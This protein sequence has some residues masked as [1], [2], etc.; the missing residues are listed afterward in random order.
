MSAA[1]YQYSGFCAIDPKAY[2]AEFPVASAPPTPTGP[3]ETGAAVISLAGPLCYTSRDFVTYDMILNAVRCAVSIEGAHTVALIVDSPGGDVPGAFDTAR[4]L[5]RI[6]KGAGKRFLAHTSS[7]A[8]SA[9]YALISTADEISVSSTG[10][11]GSIGVITAIESKAK[12]E[13]SL[14]LEYAIITS[15]PRKSDGNS[16]LPISRDAIDAYQSSVD[17]MASEFF[18][19][20]DEHRPGVDSR[21]LGAGIYTGQAALAVKLADV[22][23]S[24][25]QFLS[26]AGTI[27]S[28]PVVDTKL[29]T[30]AHAAAETPFMAKATDEDKKDDV[31]AALAKAAEDDSDKDMQAKAKRALAAFDKGDGEEEDNE[32]AKATANAAASL[33]ATVQTLTASVEAQKAQITALTSQLSAKAVADERAAFFASRPDLT[34][35]VV[36]SLEGVDLAVAKTIVAS[37]PVVPGRVAAMA[38]TASVADGAGKGDT[39]G[40]PEVDPTFKATAARLMGL[41]TVELKNE[42]NAA[43]HTLTL[44]KINRKVV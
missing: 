28:L 2:G 14:G 15:G 26:R 7:C 30:A 18:R 5:R 22:I 31:R 32:K 35:E 34:A 10:Q 13:A 36:K 19:L 37:I 20:V 33:A 16:H 44:G 1:R 4:E 41:D 6:I 23:E 39:Q 43:A 3:L 29:S 12:A 42:Y 24:R 21:G 38:A 25:E 40:A 17:V 11:L 9:A 8:A 27:A